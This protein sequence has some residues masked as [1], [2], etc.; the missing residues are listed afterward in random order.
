MDSAAGAP[1]MCIVTYRPGYRAPWIDRSYVTQ[2]ALPPLS[3]E[4]SLSVVR[5]VRKVDAVPDQVAEIILGKAEG[6]PFFLEELSRVVEGSADPASGP[7]GAR[8]DPGGP[9][10]P[11]R[12]AGRGAA[13]A[14]PDRRR[15]RPRGAAPRCSA[16]SGAASWTRICASS[17]GSQFLYVKTGGG[18]P[19][20]R[21]HPQPDAGRGLREP[22]ARAPAGAPR[23][24]RPGARGRLRRSARGGLRPARVSLQPD[25][26]GRTRPSST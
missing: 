3:R 4:D 13:A 21:V 24:D 18:E 10:R 2:V 19:L 16:P 15:G 22:A 14:S 8:H 11:D 5:S 1:A 20:S 9:P 6:N 17:C 23:R 26:R 25:R 12:P 7:G